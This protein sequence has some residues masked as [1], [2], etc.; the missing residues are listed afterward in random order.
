M[1]IPVAA[2]MTNLMEAKNLVDNMILMS[3][4]RPSNAAAVEEEALVTLGP[5]IG[6]TP[7]RR[8]K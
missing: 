1:V 4:K 5:K 6:E 3:L 2:T 8:K 7:L